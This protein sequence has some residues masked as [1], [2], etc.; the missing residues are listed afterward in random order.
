MLSAA[1]VVGVILTGCKSKE[2]AVSDTAAAVSA[3]PTTAANGTATDTASPTGTAAVPAPLTDGNVAALL[4]EAN[5]GDSS[6]AAAA[7]PSLTSTGTKNFARLMMGEHHALRVQGDKV[8]SAQNITM[9]SPTPDPFKPAVEAETNALSSMTKGP[10][11]D[12]T[13]IA[14]EIDIHQAVIDWA[15][16][17]TPQNAALQAYMKSAGPTLVKHLDV[18]KRLMKKMEHK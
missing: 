11:Y 5:M 7:L 13:Y 8:A 17:T 3:A 4:D 14:N 6:L 1:V 16:K 18:A 9:Q 15:G 2:P 12:S 10:A